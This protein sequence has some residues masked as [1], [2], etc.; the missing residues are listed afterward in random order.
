MIIACVRTCSQRWKLFSALLKR[1]ESLS[2]L[3]EMRS[4]HTLEAEADACI[5]SRLTARAALSYCDKHL[6]EEDA[7]W[8]LFLEDDI[9]VRRELRDA[10]DWLAAYGT[11]HQVDCWYLCNRKNRI[12]RQFHENG[13]VINELAWPVLGSHALLIPRRHLK[14]MLDRHWTRNVDSEMFAAMRESAFNLRSNFP[15]LRSL[16]PFGGEGSLRVLQVIS[17]VLVEHRGEY[18]TFNPNHRFKLEVNHAN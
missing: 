12:T 13:F 6:P 2:F 4:F 11:Q 10:I 3:F 16:S 1:V 7:S 17:P 14:P 15:H 5:N 8:M 9:D 18:S